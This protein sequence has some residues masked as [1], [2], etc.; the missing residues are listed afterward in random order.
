MLVRSRVALRIGT[1]HIEAYR[2]GISGIGR[3]QALVEQGA[4]FQIGDLP[5][6]GHVG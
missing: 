4:D 6:L 3:R 1:G 2:A 5:D